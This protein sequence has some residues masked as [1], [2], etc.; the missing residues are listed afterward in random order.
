[1]KNMSLIILL[2]FGL[3]FCFSL[4]DI[5]KIN[6]EDNNQSKPKG[7][8]TK[9]KESSGKEDQETISVKPKYYGIEMKSDHLIFVIDVTGSMEN[10]LDMA[11][12]EKA[13]NKLKATV[14]GGNDDKGNANDKKNDKKDA[15]KKREA[16]EGIDWEKITN[17]LDLARAE[18][19]EAIKSLEPTVS[20]VAMTYNTKI[21]FLQNTFALADAKAKDRVIK[22]IS[23]Y[24]PE[25]ATDAFFEALLKAVSYA[26][27]KVPEK[28][29]G[30]DA[31][32]ATTTGDDKDKTAKKKE[33]PK[34]A[35]Y[36]VF[37]LTDG[38]PTINSQTTTILMP[39]DKIEENLKKLQEAVDKK[40]V[41]IHAIGIGY[42][43][44][45]LMQKI[46]EIGKGEYVN[47][48]P[49]DPQGPPPP[50]PPP[51]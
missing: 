17:H 7:E 37:F 34:E 26:K 3:I 39:D 36:E 23:V 31:K 48:G 11:V 40:N 1:M 16:G 50:P 24:K 33:E 22:M 19:I 51:K 38:A 42:H 43:N 6:A 32:K 15:K 30:K 13:K 8:E 12:K 2:I 41:C 28:P 46:A 14:T 4:N 44:V 49:D 9:P 45:Q 25:G 27:D 35:P 21:V 20:F 18:F 10:K 29:Q 47:M 5:R